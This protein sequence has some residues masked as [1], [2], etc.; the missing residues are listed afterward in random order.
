[1][2]IRNEYFEEA[3]IDPSGHLK[4]SRGVEY[5]TQPV[6]WHAVTESYGFWMDISHSIMQLLDRYFPEKD[7]RRVAQDIK[8][9]QLSRKNRSVVRREY[10]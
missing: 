3:L 4:V 9:F 5:Y 2:K 8:F 1:M 7:D 10:F 6:F